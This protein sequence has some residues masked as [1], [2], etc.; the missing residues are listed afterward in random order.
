MEVGRVELCRSLGLRY[1]DMEEAGVLM[2]VVEVGCRYFAPARYDDEIAVIT[3]VDKLGSRS[4]QF[5]YEMRLAADDTK[6]AQGFSKH[7]FCDRSFKPVRL[8]EHYREVFG[9]IIEDSH[10]R[11]NEAA[12]L[13]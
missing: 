8:P 12:R 11:L 13:A 9:R 4:M 2:A 7:V 1:R 5:S 6:L 10:D 3:R